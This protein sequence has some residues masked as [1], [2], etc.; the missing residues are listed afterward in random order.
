M[1]DQKALVVKCKEREIPFFAIAGTDEL[2]ID[3]TKTYLDL[4]R[5]NGADRDFVNDM[6][7]VVNEMRDFKRDEPHL[8]KI[9][10]FSNEVNDS[11]KSLSE[12]VVNKCTT[13]DIPVIVFCGTDKCALETMRFYYNNAKA[14]EYPD[15]YIEKVAEKAD[16]FFNFAAQNRDK[17]KMPDMSGGSI[18]RM[19]FEKAAKLNQ[20]TSLKS[21]LGYKF[22]NGKEIFSITDGAVDRHGFISDVILRDSNGEK[23]E[24]SYPQLVEKVQNGAYV[25]VDEKIVTPNYIINEVDIFSLREGGYGLTAKIN[26]EKYPM[27]KLTKEDV[28][29][30]FNKKDISGRQ[31]A[32]KHYKDEIEKISQ[33]PEK[34]KTNLDN[35]IEM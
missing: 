10:G 31:L 23:S 34:E 13:N 26:K 16:E 3:V 15:H 35:A 30:Y 33:T 22:S 8:V 21:I 6:I 11:N 7:D 20:K 29:R 19:T 12:L 28:D 2:A 17:I 25:T 1:K 27:K 24:I 18:E 5:Q 4:I 14:L 9:P 32:E